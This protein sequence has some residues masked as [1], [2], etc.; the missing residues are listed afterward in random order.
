MAFVILECRPARAIQVSLGYM[1]WGRV[2]HHREANQ[3]VGKL[4]IGEGGL[5]LGIERAEIFLI[6]FGDFVNRRALTSNHELT[7]LPVLNRRRKLR[8]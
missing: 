3:E 1:G 2:S 8:D 4:K 5:G 6:L 7:H